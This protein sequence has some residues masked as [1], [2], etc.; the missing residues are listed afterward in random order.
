VAF[1]V[2][3]VQEIEWND[4]LFTNLVLPPNQKKLIKAL[5]KDH[6]GSRFD[7]FIQG[8]GRGLVV[9]LFGKPGV[10]KSLTVEATSEC[11]F[12]L[13]SD[14]Q[15]DFTEL[16]LHQQAYTVLCMLLAPLT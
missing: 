15:Q 3:L 7:D 10:G 4:N 6:N 5:V 14:I 11:M 12:P 8:K 1:C 16:C 9:N 13:Y 2:R